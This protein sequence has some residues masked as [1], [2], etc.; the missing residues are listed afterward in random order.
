LTRGRHGPATWD[1]WLQAHEGRG[2]QALSAASRAGW[3]TMPGLVAE[4]GLPVAT[5]SR[6]SRAVET[7]EE[8]GET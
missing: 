6:L 2:D 3:K 7:G 1:G 8:K 5:V 4:G